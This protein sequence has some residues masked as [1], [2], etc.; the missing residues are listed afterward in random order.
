[1]EDSIK[2]NNKEITSLRANTLV[3]HTLQDNVHAL[4]EMEND[5]RLKG[6]DILSI[7]LTYQG[8]LK[9]PF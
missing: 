7:C 9:S 1:M 2:Q 8:P 4:H 6:G 5:L 3:M